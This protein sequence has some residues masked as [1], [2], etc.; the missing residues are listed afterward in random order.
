MRTDP[1]Q[2]DAGSAVETKNQTAGGETPPPNFRIS[3]NKSTSISDSKYCSN[4]SP[5]PNNFAFSLK[6]V[7]PFQQSIKIMKLNF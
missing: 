6:D 1:Q 3:I 7:F 4:K 2:K 5:L